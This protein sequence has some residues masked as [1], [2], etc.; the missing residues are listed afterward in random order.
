MYAVEFSLTEDHRR[1][2]AVCRELAAGFAT[3]AA[4]HD[5]EASSPLE[6]YVALRDAGLYGLTVPKAL[7]GWG[8][9]MLGY[10]LAA[11]E[12]AQG[13]ASTALSFNMH[14][15]IL[16]G[17]TLQTPYS[18]ETQQRAAD[19]AVGERKLISALLSEPG[20]TNLL[21]STRASTTQA[22]RVADGYVLNG[23]KAFASMVEASDYVAV[24]V[25]PE[26]EPNPAAGVL[27][28][29]P[30]DTPGIR[31]EHVWDTLGM[32]GTRSDT[33]CFE[34][35]LVPHDAV[36]DELILP[37]IP[38]WLAAEEALVNLPYT[39][40]YL[41]VGAAVLRAIT[42]YVKNRQPRGYAQPVAYHPDVRR[43]VA[44]ISSELE[45]ARWLL[46]YAAWLVDQDA[47]ANATLAAYLKAK[48]V[49][50]ETVARATRSAL[51]LGGGHAIFKGGDIERLF[52]DGATATIMQPSSDVCLHALSVHELQ[53]DH[54]QIT[55]PVKLV[56]S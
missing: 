44:K 10:T 30:T 11:E 9:G 41:G 39:A 48:Y 6:N 31:I 2:Q 32:R 47:R 4:R 40:V 8:A 49:V 1:I 50:G 16:L 42:D 56:G 21:Y 55:P 46:R 17:L 43:R 25:H 13:C 45:A 15:V 33:V 34:D 37:S 20:T 54:N 3:H 53:L 22:R 28:L 14:C 36:L 35:C 26:H 7:G 5:R 29:I 19:L 12:L 27:A 23:K 18:E 24:F 52:R 51:E 38:D